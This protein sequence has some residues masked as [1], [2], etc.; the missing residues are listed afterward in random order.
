MKLM[1][2]V[3]AMVLLA[4]RLDLYAQVDADTLARIHKALDASHSE[5]R[6]TAVPAQP[7][8]PQPTLR[9]RN[10]TVADEVAWG[11][12]LGALL[13]AGQLLFGCFNTTEPE[14]DT[15]NK[16]TTVRYVAV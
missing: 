8:R 15:C 2:S 12:A 3:L 10:G 9:S 14:V 6:L 4:G 11:A 5:R 16:A 1:C 7:L 13:P